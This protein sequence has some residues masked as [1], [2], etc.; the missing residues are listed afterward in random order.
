[1]R[2]Y[3]AHIALH[4]RYEK[5]MLPFSGRP[6]DLSLEKANE[7]R[8]TMS[9]GDMM[10]AKGYYPLT[11]KEVGMFLTALGFL[12]NTPIYIAA[13]EIYGAKAMHGDLRRKPKSCAYKL[14]LTTPFV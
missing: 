14:K 4:L 2:S 3:G 6:H 10:R 7:L 1:M 12:S 9:V 13:G 11:P 8:I 5:D